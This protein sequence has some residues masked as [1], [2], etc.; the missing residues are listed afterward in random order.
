MGETRIKLTKAQYDLFVWMFDDCERK[1]QHACEN[2][3]FQKDC[4][5]MFLKVGELYRSN[6]T[7]SPEKES[8]KPTPGN[9][10]FE[11]H[12]QDI[13]PCFQRLRKGLR[14]VRKNGILVEK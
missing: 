4:H 14:V 12:G 5:D 9:P 10:I 3:G 13:E 11:N 7:P 2:C 1:Q 8:R 6:I